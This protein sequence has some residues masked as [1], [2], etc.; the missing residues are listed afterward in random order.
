M[1][2]QSR[3][4]SAPAQRPSVI[5]AV[6]CSIAVIV[7]LGIW[8]QVNRV[9]PASKMDSP[10]VALADNSPLEEVIRILI[11][12]GHGGKD[13]GATGPTGLMEKDVALDVSVRLAGLLKAQGLA[14]TL[15]RTGDEAIALNR[16]AAMAAEINADLLVSVH[17][18]ALPNSAQPLVETYYFRP[19]RHHRRYK[20][21][22]TPEH[23]KARNLMADE[24]ERLAVHVQKAV[25][26]Q[27]RNQNANVIDN[28]VRTRGFRVLRSVSIPAVLAELTVLT[29]PQEEARLRSDVYRD[30]LANALASGVLGYLRGRSDSVAE[31]VGAEY[32]EQIVGTGPWPATEFIGTR[33]DPTAPARGFETIGPSP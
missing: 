12:P 3:E 22:Y 14:V 16:R 4:F 7:G 31:I 17:I 18:N 28:G 29:V 21:H 30:Q 1:Q 5:W 20:Q 33:Q 19:R 15:T 26:E 23:W 2:R 6:T 10:T 27:V 8:L 9:E 32:N 24:S 13:P 11:D 25:L